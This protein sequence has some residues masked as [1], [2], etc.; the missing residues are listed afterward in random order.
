[1]DALYIIP[2]E[3]WLL[4]EYIWSILSPAPVT[5]GI[6]GSPRGWGCAL[7]PTSHPREHLLAPATLRWR[8][9]LKWGSKKVPRGSSPLRVCL[10]R[11][12]SSITCFTN[13]ATVSRQSQ[14]VVYV[15][16]ADETPCKQHEEQKQTYS[17][18]SEC[19]CQATNYLKGEGIL[20]L[21]IQLIL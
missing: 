19:L 20:S 4:A 1:M 15:S 2:S 3:G 9:G 14:M 8:P 11:G 7:S 17:L 12:A 16:S 21:K 13:T 6:T 10:G 5:P 18:H